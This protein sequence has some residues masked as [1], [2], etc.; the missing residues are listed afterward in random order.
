MLREMIRGSAG[1]RHRT[2]LVDQLTYIR[3]GDGVK[4]IPAKDRV[5]HRNTADIMDASHSET[6]K[7]GQGRE[8]GE[9][10][11]CACIQRGTQF[12]TDISPQTGIRFLV[13]E[14]DVQSN[15]LADNG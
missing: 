5:F 3:F 13:N 7:G 8:E 2:L 4:R 12:S 14:R 9:N 1:Y 10:L 15:G 6:A 11:C